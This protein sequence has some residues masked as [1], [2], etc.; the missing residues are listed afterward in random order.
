MSKQLDHGNKF[1]NVSSR[2]SCLSVHDQVVAACADAAP[3]L[4]LGSITNPI[5]NTG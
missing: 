2:D 3:S 5:Q 4:R 1:E